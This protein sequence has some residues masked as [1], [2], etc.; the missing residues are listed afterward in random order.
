MANNLPLV[1]VTWND[2]WTKE[3]GVAIDDVRMHHAPIVVTTIGYLLLQDEVGVSIAN[4]YYDDI[5]RGRTFIPGGM[6][7]SVT[8]YKLSKPRTP[9]TPTE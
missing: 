4:E 3:D 9:K 6:V 8:P 5:Y 2:A 1:V 7:R